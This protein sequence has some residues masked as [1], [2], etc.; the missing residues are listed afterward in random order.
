MSTNAESRS[1]VVIVSGGSRGL[2]QA[3]V[4]SCL[5]RG[6]IVATFSRSE[7]PFVTNLLKQDPEHQRFLWESVDAT[8]P[9]ALKTFVNKV[10]S[11][12]GRVDALVNNAGVGI[13]GILTT[14]RTSQIEQGIDLN[15]KSAI[16]LIQACSKHMLQQ[17]SGSIINVSSVNAVRGHSGVAVYS[18]TKAALDGLTRSLARELGPKHIRVNSVAPGYFESEMVADLTPEAKQRIIRRTP[19]G[20]LGTADDMAQ[21]VQFLLS[22]QASFITGQTIVVDGGITC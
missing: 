20:R 12:Y 7:S 6:F 2:G 15:L 13:D 3:L 21:V 16:Y 8:D 10:A 5:E 19:L 9:A 14:M 18:A 4:T 11:T 22:P 17:Q 1:K